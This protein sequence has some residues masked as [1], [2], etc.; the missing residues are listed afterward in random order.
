MTIIM[1]DKPEILFG[2]AKHKPKQQHQ[3]KQTT[4]KTP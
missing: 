1:D 2:K 3:N 4:N